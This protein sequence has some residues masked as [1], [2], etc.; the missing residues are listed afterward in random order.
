LRY[1]KERLAAVVFFTKCSS[2]VPTALQSLSANEA[3]LQLHAD[4]ATWHQHS[5]DTQQRS[6]HAGII[7]TSIGICHFVGIH[8]VPR[9]SSSCFGG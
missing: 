8:G 2:D 3:G 6:W 4:N 9:Q 5:R 1:V 7:N